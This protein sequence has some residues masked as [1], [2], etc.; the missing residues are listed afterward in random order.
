MLWIPNLFLPPSLCVVYVPPI[1]SDGIGCIGGSVVECLP[2]AQGVGIYGR[3]LPGVLYPISSY[4]FIFLRFYL[5]VHERQRYRQKQLP[6]GSRMRDS[7]PG[8]W[9]HALSQRLNH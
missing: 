5:F 4:L 9:D 8:P 1:R 3:P 7:V 2:L 6:A